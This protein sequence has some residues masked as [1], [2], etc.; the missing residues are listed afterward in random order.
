[1]NIK[2]FVLLILISMSSTLYAAI[3]P[4]CLSGF[5][6]GIGLAENF[7][8]FEDQY[9]FDAESVLN[10]DFYDRKH[11]FTVFE[12]T[13]NVT[14]GYARLVNNVLLGL[15]FN[16]NF[17][18]EHQNENEDIAS[19]NIFSLSNTYSLWAR[20]GYS[21]CTQTIAYGLFGVAT[22][23]L[24]RHIL[25]TGPFQPINIAP[26]NQSRRVWGP[27]I[28]VGVEQLL[29][30]HWHIGLEY[31]HIFYDRV[32]YALENNIFKFLG[33]IGN[34]KVKLNQD[35]VTLKLIYAF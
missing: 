35:T 11:H 6:A 33:S 14:V 29:T 25:F 12:L 1:M 13:P 22:T 28:G 31:S 3:N 21:F 30:D 15:E 5:Y 17:I 27:V 7:F 32:N 24:T 26:V 4:L 10:T 16:A 2:T 9:T 18:H 34:N 8:S 20:L 19:N 23:G